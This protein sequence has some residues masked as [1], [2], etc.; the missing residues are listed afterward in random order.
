MA[1]AD[2]LENRV[3]DGRYK[4][5]TN[6]VYGL[7]IPVFIAYILYCANKIKQLVKY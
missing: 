5:Y 7:Y 6:T 1:D 4:A 3:A 2:I